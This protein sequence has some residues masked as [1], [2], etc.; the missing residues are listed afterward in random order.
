MNIPVWQPMSELPEDDDQA[1]QVKM[2][3]EGREMISVLTFAADWRTRAILKIAEGYHE[4]TPFK[5]TAWRPM[6]EDLWRCAPDTPETL[7]AREAEAAERYKN[8]AEYKL[9]R[10]ED[11]RRWRPMSEPPKAEG[12]YCVRPST[13]QWTECFTWEDGY[14]MCRGQ[15]CVADLLS[16]YVWTYI[17]GQEPAE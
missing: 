12:F 2:E 1:I 4:I 10:L 15:R 6:N 11:L 5:A 8:S 14:W 13:C 9:A 3:F 17:P 16:D 7:A